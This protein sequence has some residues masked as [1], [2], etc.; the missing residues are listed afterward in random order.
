MLLEEAY[1]SA[2]LTPADCG[3]NGIVLIVS[4]VVNELMRNAPRPKPVAFFE[5]NE[6]KL[7]LNK[8]NFAKLQQL[9][10]RPNSDHWTGHR[11]IAFAGSAI[12]APVTLGADCFS[13]NVNGMDNLFNRI[14]NAKPAMPAPDIKTL[15]IFPLPQ[16]AK[17]C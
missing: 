9:T 17:L 16:D 5:N 4:Q 11:F 6:K 2:Y 12:P 1:P 15:M 8:T 14:A 3:P 10:G 13:I 7:P